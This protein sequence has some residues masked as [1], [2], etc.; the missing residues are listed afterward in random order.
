MTTCPKCGNEGLKYHSVYWCNDI[1]C[2]TMWTDWQQAQIDGLRN[3]TNTTYEQLSALHEDAV[4]MI[5]QQRDEIENLKEHRDNVIC[6]GKNMIQIMAKDGAWQSMHGGG[7][8]AAD[9]L[10][11]QDPYKEIDRLLALLEEIDRVKLDLQI[12][13][14]SRDDWQKNYDTLADNNAHLRA[15][16]TE[17][18]D[19]CENGIVSGKVQKIAAIAKKG[20][21]K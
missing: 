16:L 10:Y 12:M 2:D 3:G 5:G 19:V 9:D 21:D 11:G 18:E 4:K 13:T 20:L 6:V 15:V 17:I 7:V 1:K 14:E 8:V